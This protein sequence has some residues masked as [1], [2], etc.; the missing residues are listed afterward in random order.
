MRQEFPASQGTLHFRDYGSYIE[1]LKRGET[2]VFDD[3][4]IDPRTSANANAL[5]AISAQ[6][7]V[8]MPVTEHGG[9]VALLYLNHATP[10]TWRDDDLALISEVA[11]RTRTAVERL[12]AEQALRE[13]EARL[14]FLD[15]LGKE[16]AVATD[17]EAIM[18]ITTRLLGEHLD[19][20]ICAYADMEPDQ[21]HFTIRGDWGAPGSPSIAGY[22]SLADFGRLAVANLGAG[23]PLIVNDNRAELAPEEAQ[24]FLDIGIAAT[25]CMPLVKQGRLTALMAIHDKRP[26]IWTERELDLLSEVTERSWA[27]IER[28]RSEQAA[29]ASDERLEACHR[30]RLNWYVG[31]QSGHRS[32]PLG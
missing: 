15:S 19:V 27:H 13:S 30:C 3:A 31:L 16:I 23:R 7:V 20:S 22:Y 6:S 29:R 8:N 21:D 4:E 5:K 1:D 28:V 18:I 32:T 10:R 9:F 12:R 25:I 24:T 26:R 2:V 17:A 14:K 11:H